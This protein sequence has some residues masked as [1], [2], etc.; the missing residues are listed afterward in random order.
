M[1]E[2]KAY[3]AL[4]SNSRLGILKLLYRE[5]LS[6]EDIAKKVNLKTITVRHHLNSLMDAG[7]VESYEEKKGTVGR[8]KTIYKMAREPT[9]VTY[10]KRRYL[11]LSNFMIKTLQSLIGPR[12]ATQIFRNVGRNM[13]KNVVS[14]LEFKHGIE[15]WSSDD[16]VN[17][18]LMEYL[19]EAGAEPEIIKVNSK[20][21]IYRVHNCLFLELAVKM[22]K[23]MCEQL[24]DAFHEGVSN[25]MGPDF[26]IRRLSC[27]GHGDPYCEHACNLSFPDSK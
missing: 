1:S 9:L 11:N 7:L 20:Q 6:A 21:I 12:R 26:K 10:P 3:E 13:G 25:A 23:I 16:F 27:Q 15:K 14:E 22:P 4:S 18:F 24:H 2:R 19:E 17:F 8:P 5:P